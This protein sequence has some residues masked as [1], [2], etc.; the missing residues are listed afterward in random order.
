MMFY[1]LA[2]EVAGHWG[3]GTV[4]D[5]SEHPPIAHS[6]HYEFDGWLDELLESFPCYTRVSSR[7]TK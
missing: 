3:P 1:E 2:P 6:L 4:M 5:A 7:R